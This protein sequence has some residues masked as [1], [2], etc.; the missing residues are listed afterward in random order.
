[1]SDKIY[2]KNTTRSNLNNKTSPPILNYISDYYNNNNDNSINNSNDLNRLDL[3]IV[4]VM[5]M[6]MMNKTDS[7]D[8]IV[9]SLKLNFDTN[10]SP[11]TLFSVFVS[12]FLSFLP[13]LFNE[14]WIKNMISVHCHP[15]I[16][17][18]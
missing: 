16:P 3:I 15:P 10:T 5:D 18:F 4:L 14:G 13:P 2:D 7:Y 12:L 11:Q 8:N 17:S 9:I 6:I 1:M